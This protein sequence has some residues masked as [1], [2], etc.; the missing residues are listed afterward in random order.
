MTAND[1]LNREF[2]DIRCKLIELASSLDRIDRADGSVNR[3]SRL[4][5]VQQALT[6]L[7][8]D[9]PE[10]SSQIQMIFSLPYDDKWQKNFG[11]QANQ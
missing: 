7:Q 5:K 9:I 4:E 1:V 2:L 6:V 8:S 10:R 11:M 3:D